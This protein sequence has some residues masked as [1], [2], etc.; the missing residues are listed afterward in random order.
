MT[1]IPAS[2]ARQSPLAIGYTPQNSE[3][4]CGDTEHKN[5]SGPSESHVS[6]IFYDSTIPF[7]RSHRWYQH[8]RGD[9]VPGLQVLMG[10]RT[11]VKRLGSLHGRMSVAGQ[12]WLSAQ[13]WP[14]HTYLRHGSQARLHIR[15][16]QGAVKKLWR[17]GPT[18]RRFWFNR[19]GMRPRQQCF[20]RTPWV[21][22]MCSQG[23]EPLACTDYW[24]DFHRDG[25]LH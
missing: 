16:T 25:W 11:F 10:W 1:C 12:S 5:Q 7:N 4:C 8:H 6:V 13:R 24:G 22:L 19:P 15:I 21:V 18:P 9:T 3:E 20:V 23:W 14:L 2:T 17:W